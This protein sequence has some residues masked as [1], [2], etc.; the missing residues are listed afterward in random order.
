MVAGVSKVKGNDEVEE[1]F[2]Y[3]S[4]NYP[5]D[6]V[7]KSIEILEDENAAKVDLEGNINVAEDE[8]ESQIEKIEDD[9]G[10]IAFISL[11]W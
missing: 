7:E 4:Q 1:I 9:V 11:D 10:N 3:I 2:S 6:I 8:I 5:I